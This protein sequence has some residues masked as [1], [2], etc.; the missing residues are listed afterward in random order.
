[1][2][3]HYAWGKYHALTCFLCAA[4]AASLHGWKLICEKKST[5][6]ESATV[7]A[8]QH[9]SVFCSCTFEGEQVRHKRC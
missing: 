5:A 4:S 8:I 2:Y 1:M 9:Q 3:Y 7:F 6:E